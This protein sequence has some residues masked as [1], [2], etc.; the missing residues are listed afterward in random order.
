VSASPGSPRSAG[1]GLFGTAPPAGR[2]VRASAVQGLGG[3]ILYL[4]EL[5]QGV[6]SAVALSRN[7]ELW[8]LGERV[9]VGTPRLTEL[10]GARLATAGPDDRPTLELLALCGSLPL[11]DVKQVAPIEA[12][13]DLERAGLVYSVTDRQRTYICLAHP[14]YAEV[15]RSG[16]SAIRRLVL[17]LRRPEDLHPPRSQPTPCRDRRGFLLEAHAAATIGPARVGRRMY[18]PEGRA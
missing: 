16:I 8:E 17:L 4:R 5:T 7:G 14:M 3:N 1:S 15:A 10:I 13:L 12:V 2:E 6:L 9:L 11:D 18:R